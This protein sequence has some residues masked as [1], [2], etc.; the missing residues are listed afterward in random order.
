MLF[1]IGVILTSFSISYLT[2]DKLLQQKGGSVRE[3]NVYPLKRVSK[4]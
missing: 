4:P 2:A 3:N 1:T